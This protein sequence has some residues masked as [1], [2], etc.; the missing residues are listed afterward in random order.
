MALLFAAHEPRLKG[1]IA[2][3][4]CCDL[5][6]HHREVLADRMLNIM[7]NDLRHFVTRN[8]P[9]THAERIKCPVFLF[10]SKDDEV[11]PRSDVVAL[12]H[13]LR[14]F[15]TSVDTVYPIAGDHGSM[16]EKGL[17]EGIKW[18]QATAKKRS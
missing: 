16:L 5:V 13:K 3:A 17:P 2:Y 6:N 18:L 4:P 10:H 15:G 8:S 7:F 12:E 1:C 11:V 14:S 9:I